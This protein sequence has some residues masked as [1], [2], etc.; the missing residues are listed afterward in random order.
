VTKKTEPGRMAGIVG[1][2]LG[3]NKSEQAH[4]GRLAAIG[5][6]WIARLKDDRGS[7]LVEFAVVLPVMISILTGTASFSM[8]LYN[9]Q[10][11]GF[12]VSNASQLVASQQGLLA[13][14]DPCATAVTSVTGAL[15]HW[16]AGNFTYTVTITDSAGTAHTYGP[17]AGSSFSCTAGYALMADNEPFALTV[18]YRYTWLPIL[19]FSPSGNL[20]ASQTSVTE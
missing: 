11:L 6:H 20:S 13:N 7:A 16:T 9:Y 4:G 2:W 8:F 12:T 14:G 15:P 3:K 19:S 5:R 17:T 1:R 18:T 10:Q